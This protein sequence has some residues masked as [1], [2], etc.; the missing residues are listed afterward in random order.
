M[1]LTDSEAFELLLINYMN[2]PYTSEEAKYV[3]DVVLSMAKANPTVEG[4]PVVRCK[5][6]IYYKPT[7]FIPSLRCTNSFYGDFT[8]TTE[9]Y[10]YCSRGIRKE[11]E[12]EDNG[13]V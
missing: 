13:K 6:C 9:K 5:D 8:L 12:G 10:D 4:V 1:R 3:L 7:R 11:S 2:T